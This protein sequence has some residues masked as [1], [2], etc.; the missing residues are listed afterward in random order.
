MFK[1]RYLIE[2]CWG[3]VKK[4]FPVTLYGINKYTA[5]DSQ[6][7]AISAIVLHN[8][9]REWNE[10]IKIPSTL[11]NTASEIQEMVD[12]SNNNPPEPL[13]NELDAAAFDPEDNNYIRNMIIEKYF[14]H[15]NDLE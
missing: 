5:E 7:V 14:T 12:E 13:L 2:S 8:L 11:P 6:N 15:A 4:Q 1:P 9:A 10:E 3:L